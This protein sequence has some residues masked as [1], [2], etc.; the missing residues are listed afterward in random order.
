MARAPMAPAAAVAGGDDAPT[1]AGI[2]AGQPMGGDDEGAEAS[3]VLTVLKGPDGS[4]VLG[5]GDESDDDDEN[6]EG[7]SADDMAA[8]AGGGA[9]G[10]MGGGA[11]MG[12]GEDA[13]QHYT[14]IGALMKG[15]MDMLNE[16]AAGGG[17]GGA[18]DQFA[19]GFNDQA[20]P[21]PRA[22]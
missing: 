5:K 14:S 4:Y 7:D 2:G 9:A 10:G 18:G 16:D 20:G 12:G 13:G 3:V 6:N 11:G 1:D 8:G 15:I 17:A 22:A 21:T 19:A